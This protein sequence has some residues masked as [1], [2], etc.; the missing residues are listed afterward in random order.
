MQFGML[1]GAAKLQKVTELLASLEKDLKESTL[2]TQQRVQT[3]L[4][5]RQHGTNPRDADPIYSK[6]GLEVLMKYGVDGETADVRR[7][8]LR[9]VANALLL[10][11]NMGQVFVDTGYASRLAEGLKCD[12]SDDEMMASRILAFS[13]NRTTMD[14]EKLISEHALGT[15]LNYQI[16]RHA[17]QFPEPGKAAL[18]Q[19]DQLAL[20]DTLKL[21]YL[22]ASRNPKLA[23]T[24]S[25][26]L[27]LMF[28][29]LSRADI[30]AKPLDEVA[31][32]LINCI[33]A[34]D[35]SGGNV[36]QLEDN[37]LFP[38]ANENAIADK[39]IKI[40]DKT[41]SAYSPA[42]L[43]P[44]AIPLLYTLAVIC[45]RAPD[46]PREHMKQLL[47]PESEDRT[48]PIGQS[49]T[50]PSKLLKTTKTP[51][52]QLRMLIFELM[53][54]LSDRDAETLTKNIGY[55]YA[56]GFLATRGI[57]V[58]KMG[59]EGESGG[60]NPEINPITGQ[61]WSAEPQDTGPPMTRE[62]KEREAERLFVL[63]ERARANGI[64]N[65]ENP[66]RLA[67]QEG[68]FEELSDSDSE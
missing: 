67:Q 35:N 26:S 14:V 48:Q 37:I 1:Q 11:P 10:N 15:N 68:R 65:V 44:R 64:L 50:L 24:F 54:V 28:T 43:E 30:P 16:S 33:S 45:E 3:L 58:P 17:A 18:S 40:L 49:D 51:Y 27:P 57:E 52:S 29:I 7:S 12:A 32:Q 42:E 23:E 9:C 53:F 22:I 60:L 46:G 8:A 41:M 19:M 4:E 61:K 55:G 62:E 47:L 21:I 38:E 20:T 56:A 36:K 63:F 66:V 5:L 39:L 59:G 31:G 13:S 2:T 6:D 34:L 25:P